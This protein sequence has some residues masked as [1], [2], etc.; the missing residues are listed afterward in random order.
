MWKYFAFLTALAVV[1]PLPLRIGYLVA[2]VAAD[3]SFLL[4]NCSRA[5]VASNVRHVLGPE[6]DDGLVK[7][8]TLG[9]FRTTARNLF[10]LIALPR[11][12]LAAMESR[13]DIHGWHHLEEAL[14]RGK[15]V[16]LASIH[17]GNTDMA[18]QVVRAR[19]A[20]M[21][22]LSEVVQPLELDRLSRRLREC[23]GISL[24]PVTYS[25][26][27]EAIRRLKR[28]E[29]VAIACDRAIQR[30]GLSME[31]LG[32]PALIPVGAVDLALRTG[33]A[34]VPAFAARHKGYR[35]AFYFEPPIYVPSNGN[36]PNNIRQP[37]GKIVSWMEKYIRRFPDQWMV[38][39]PVW[40]GR[41][42]STDE[43]APPSNRRGQ[44]ADFTGVETP[45]PVSRGSK[46][47][48]A[49]SRNK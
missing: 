44:A 23:N 6:A 37:L 33:A 46:G 41:A 11:F 45:A 35:Y 48:V 49:T 14:A 26:L 7:H 18:V 9:V 22:I 16:V 40:D 12:D 30:S 34:I 8:V 29:V 15:G 19:S 10:D 5:G 17:L 42:D 32:A 3:I 47:H 20:K 43:A 2:R 31:F 27:K 13:V 38:F 21:T 24:L 1:A 28:G 25:G 36:R 4:A 39:R